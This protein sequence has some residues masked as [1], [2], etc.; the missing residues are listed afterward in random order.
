MTDREALIALNQVQG[1][2]SITVKRMI[3][4]FGSAGAIFE[5]AELDLV[6]VQGISRD[7]AHQLHVTLKDVSAANELERAAKTGVRLVTWVDP[8][9]P[10][11]LKE[12]ADPS[13]VLYVAGEPQALSGPSIA[14]V[15]TRHPTIYGR[16]MARLF[17]YRLAS[18]G[19]VVISG[20]AV[21]ID[22][23]A[24][25][26]AVKAKGRTVAV[27]GGALDCLFPREN[28]GLAREIVAQ[29]GAVVSEY[30][31]GR[32]P[33]R[34]TFPMRNRIVSGLSKGVLVVE[35][36]YNSG[37]LITVNQ[38]LDQGR[39]VM[40]VPGRVDSPVSQGCHRLLREGARLVTS[41]D[42]VLEE[43][44]DLITGMNRQ[45]A[46]LK[47]RCSEPKE[48]AG[49]RPEASLSK[50]ER[51]VLAQIDNEE[52]SVDQVVRESGLDAGKVN[53]LLVG[54]RIKRMVQLLP[55]GRVTRAR[56]ID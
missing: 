18:A 54:L 41:A 2:G 51:C 24:H 46:T 6:L 14:V 28:A 48:I 34:Q 50:E 13:L 30:P 29:G 49:T 11:L 8:E 43:V 3:D 23:E 16:E 19:Y 53:A 52:I 47:T 37:T 27:L 39:V 44:E 40:A 21:G 9:Y 38:A 15:G 45:G 55:G 12:I 33:D 1:L 20:L 4:R 25:T 5:A 7:R 42:E 56:K 17:G 10:V 35:A 36:P 32:Q 26:G 31:F 22:T